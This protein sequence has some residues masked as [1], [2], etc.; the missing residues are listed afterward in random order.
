MMM[1]LIISSRRRG[2]EL[3]SFHAGLAQVRRGGG[4]LEAPSAFGPPFVAS[5]SS[6]SSSSRYHAKNS[7]AKK[8]QTCN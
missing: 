8:A 2:G 5:P 3:I 1:S 6:F 4:F 7:A